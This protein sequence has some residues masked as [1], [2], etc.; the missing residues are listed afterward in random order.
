MECIRWRMHGTAIIKWLIIWCSQS[1][2][3]NCFLTEW[4]FLSFSSWCWTNHMSVFYQRIRE[5]LHQIENRPD[6]K[7]IFDGKFEVSIVGYAYNGIRRFPPEQCNR[8]ESFSTFFKI[9][10]RL[11]ALIFSAKK[12]ETHQLNGQNVFL[13]YWIIFCILRTNE[14][15]IDFNITTGNETAIWF[16]IRY[17]PYFMIYR[18]NHVKVLPRCRCIYNS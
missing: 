7:F 4:H 2:R 9:S 6:P 17:A 8:I 3:S 14:L 11:F 18:F 1:Y 10:C 5:L 13:V 16:F 12:V 15:D